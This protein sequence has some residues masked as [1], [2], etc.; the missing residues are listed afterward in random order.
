SMIGS[1][2]ST[3]SPEL[4]AY[5]SQYFDDR[6]SVVVLSD[7]YQTIFDEIKARQDSL[8]SDLN[9][10]ADSID[11]DSSA[12]RRDLQVL[13]N[14]IDAFNSDAS[15]STMTRGEYD[16]RR[17]SLEARQSTLRREYSSIQIQI[18]LY[19]QKRAE[20]E[21]INSEST[22]LNRSINSSLD[23]VPEGFDG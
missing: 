19:E 10:L 12:Y 22:A 6:A 2:V 20:L 21:A 14:D 8:V 15:S 3:L 23:Q 17:Q 18:E 5:Y 11:R 13:E 9:E 1:E 16:S 7:K 4:E